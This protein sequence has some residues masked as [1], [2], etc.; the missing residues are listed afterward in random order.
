MFCCSNVCFCLCS[1]WRRYKVFFLEKY[2]LTFWKKKW[3]SKENSNNTN[4]FGICLHYEAQNICR[5]NGLY[6]FVVFFGA[7]RAH[8][9]F[10]ACSKKSLIAPT[11]LR[12][13]WVLAVIM[14]IF[15]FFLSFLHWLWQVI[16]I[17]AVSLDLFLEKHI[18]I[19]CHNAVYTCHA[20]ETHQKFSWPTICELIFLYNVFFFFSFDDNWICFCMYLTVYDINRGVSDGDGFNIIIWETYH[21]HWINTKHISV[22]LTNPSAF[23]YIYWVQR[24]KQ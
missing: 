9:F 7:K 5:T 10:F 18:D 12:P 16:L 22:L 23:I 19:H 4:S 20:I 8:Y 21:V 15:F 17:H 13:F 24:E 1:G 6:K 14:C 11:P 2:F 3:K